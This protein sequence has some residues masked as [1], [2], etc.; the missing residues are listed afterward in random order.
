M[1]SVMK[2]LKNNDAIT[3][4]EIILV[5]VVLIGLVLIF[6]NQLTSLIQGIFQKIQSSAN[7]I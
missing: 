3:T 5:L 7:S 2:I 1:K 6:K 4:I